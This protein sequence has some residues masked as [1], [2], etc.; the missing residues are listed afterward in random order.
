MSVV[1]IVYAHVCSCARVPTR[2]TC[3]SDGIVE[4]VGLMVQQSEKTLTHGCIVAW[5]NECQCAYTLACNVVQLC[6]PA[7]TNRAMG[8]TTQNSTII[9]CWIYR[10]QT[11]VLMEVSVRNTNTRLALQ[12]TQCV[13]WAFVLKVANYKHVI[14]IWLQKFES[15]A[16]RCKLPGV[17]WVIKKGKSGGNSKG[18]PGCIT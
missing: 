8:Y 13:K 17:K 7:H 1:I 4:A 10:F 12:S 14:I 3:P 16:P 6:K 11:R 2:W 9:S 15:L 18:L 5:R